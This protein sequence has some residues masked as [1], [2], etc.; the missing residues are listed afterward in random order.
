[1]LPS[2]SPFLTLSAFLSLLSLTSLSL[3]NSKSCL[4]SVPAS[5]AVY[6]PPGTQHLFAVQ[7]CS[8]LFSSGRPSSLQQQTRSMI[9]GVAIA[10]LSLCLAYLFF[11]YQKDPLFFRKMIYFC[12]IL[13]FAAIMKIHERKNSKKPWSFIDFFEEKVD[14][15]P[16]FIQFI[17]VEDDRQ[18]TLNEMDQQG[19]QLGRWATTLGLQQKDSIAI[20]MLNK[21]EVV[22]FWLGMAKIGV[23]SALINSNVTGK[24]F[25]H[26]VE[27]SVK[28]STTKVVVIDNELKET[29]KTEVMQLREGGILVY[30]W[31]DILSSLT[32]IP[33]HRIAKTARDTIHEKDPL[34]YIFTSGTTGLPK[35]CKVSSSK[36]FQNTLPVSC[37]LRLQKGDR[38]YNCLPLYH[39]AGGMVALGGCF[40]ANATMVLR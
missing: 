34:I 26:S 9:V 12:D 30:F 22:I 33:S 1:M 39:S 21:P 27:I 25:I 6:T 3:S 11:A 29:L 18:I 4:E 37:F 35:A 15:D 23:G 10:L 13:R 40:R 19:N 17:T 5:T 36:Y 31:N 8:T 24:A 16:S 14:K 20:I 2:P 32:S 28:D 7:C 38:F